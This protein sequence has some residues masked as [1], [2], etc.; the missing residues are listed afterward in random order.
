[1]SRPGSGAAAYSSKY[2]DVWMETMRMEFDRLVAA[3]TFAEVTEIPEGCYIVDAKWLY[4]WKGD[5]YGMIDGAKARM[6]ATGHSQVEGVGYFEMFA[7]TT[8]A[9]CTGW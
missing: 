7:P 2:S 1:M 9:T 8:S 6:V 4:S 3:G 5:S